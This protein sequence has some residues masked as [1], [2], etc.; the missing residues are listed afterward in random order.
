MATN[1][2]SAAPDWTVGIALGAGG[3]LGGY[4]GALAQPHLPER[5]LRRIL[6]VL[7]TAIGARYAYLSAND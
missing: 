4:L 2:R 6:G 5:L 1:H 3:L 7:V